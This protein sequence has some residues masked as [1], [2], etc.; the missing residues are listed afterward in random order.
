MKIRRS[1]ALALTLLTV[2]ACLSSPL[3]AAAITAAVIS[4][5]VASGAVKITPGQGPAG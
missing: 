1:L 2:S 5:S 4:T 3:V